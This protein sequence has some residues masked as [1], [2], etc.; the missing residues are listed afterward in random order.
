MLAYSSGLRVSEVVT[1][2][3]EQVDVAR[4]TVFIH[5]GKGRKDRYTLLSDV[6]AESLREY[7]KLFTIEN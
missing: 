4:K 1:L 6:A 5:D 2:K 3:R 7:Y